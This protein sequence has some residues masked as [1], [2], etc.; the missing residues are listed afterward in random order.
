MT[1][2]AAL[3]R[4]LCGHWATAV[5]RE[6]LVTNGLGG[7]ACGTVAL[8]NT[9]R[10]HAFLMASLAPPVRAHAARRQDRCERR[11][12][13]APLRP[14]VERIR[15]WHGRSARLRRDRIVRR[16]RRHPRL[17]LCAGGRPPGAA[18]L[19]GAGRERELPHARAQARLGAGSNR[20]EAAHR[21]SRLPRP[22]AGWE[23]IRGRCAPRGL[24]AARLRG[25]AAVS[26]G[27]G[28][29]ALHARARRVVL[30]F[31]PSRGGGPRARCAGG[32]IRAGH[33]PRRDRLGGTRSPS[34]RARKRP[35]LRRRPA[36]RARCSSARR[37]RGRRCPRARPPGSRPWPRPRINFSCAAATRPAPTASSR[38]TPG[39][40]TGGATP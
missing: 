13:R 21:L 32:S 37:P 28:S 17:A 36:W 29:R 20:V 14:R 10:Y 1:A 23:A 3:G 11:L 16:H 7:Y 40:P 6:W 38:G 2:H 9:R 39:S 24:H 4:E 12:S 33:I 27:A 30:E 25:R 18:D 15:R 34:P 22:R 35:R 5:R 26:S 31:F 8:A 19:H